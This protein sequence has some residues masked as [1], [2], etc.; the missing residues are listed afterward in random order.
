MNVRFSFSSGKAN[1]SGITEVVLGSTPSEFLYATNL[2]RFQEQQ[3]FA[4]TEDSR[5]TSGH[6]RR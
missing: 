3:P 4:A 1:L 2:A 6:Q 5:D